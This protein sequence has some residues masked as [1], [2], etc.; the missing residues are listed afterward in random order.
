MT[1]NLAWHVARASGL[2]AWALATAT[3][4]W[5]LSLSSRIAGRRT[6][7][8]WLT[9]LHRFMGGLAVI[10]TGVHVA[11][12][13]VDDWIGFTIVD[14]LVPFASPW[15]PGAVAWGVV[16]L[17]LLAAIE[18]TSLLRRRVPLRWWRAVHHASLPM[19][20]AGTVHLL[21]A[22]SDAGTPWVR[23]IVLGAVTIVAYLAIVRLLTPRRRA[24]RRAAPP[25]GPV[26]RTARMPVLE[27]APVPTSQPAPRRRMS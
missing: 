13:L 19:A 1:T 24:A 26:R 7:R 12:L 18:L 4:V 22:G 11:A 20:F 27:T 9:D 5:G 21:A 6:P 8:A 10:F 15:R 2:V 23:G 17:Y 16:A 3:V 14:V 25:A